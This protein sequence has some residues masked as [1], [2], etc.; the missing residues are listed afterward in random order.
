[1]TNK[2]KPVIVIENADDKVRIE[3]KFEYSVNLTLGLADGNDFY[4]ELDFKELTKD[5]YK[6]LIDFGN[7][8]NRLK[9]E[10]NIV[11]KEKY[12]ITHI[13][14]T[15]TSANNLGEMKWKCLSD[16]PSLYKNL[17]G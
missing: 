8:L 9:F 6:E 14:V 17:L 5:D 4:L 15:E 10:S 11:T 1:M 12:N 3:N 7:Q 16:D 2:K 13:V